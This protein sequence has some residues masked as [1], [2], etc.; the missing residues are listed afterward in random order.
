M[1][2]SALKAEIKAMSNNKRKRRKIQ[3]VTKNYQ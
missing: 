2:Y 3:R 1:A